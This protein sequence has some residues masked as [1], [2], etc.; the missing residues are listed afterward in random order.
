MGKERSVATAAE[1]SNVDGAEDEG[2][3][4]ESTTS[5]QA[6]DHD[7]CSTARAFEKPKEQNA[8]EEVVDVPSNAELAQREN[9]DTPTRVIHFQDTVHVDMSKL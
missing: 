7:G 2:D 3:L 6:S 1:G 4:D 8:S 9:Q 5:K